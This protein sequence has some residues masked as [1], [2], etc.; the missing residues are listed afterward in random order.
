MSFIRTKFYGQAPNAPK[1]IWNCKLEYKLFM[2][3]SKS[4]IYG[5]FCA[6]ERQQMEARF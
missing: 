1:S 3:F 2:Y 6:T 5:Y 4:R